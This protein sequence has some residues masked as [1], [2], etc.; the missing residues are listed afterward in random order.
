MDFHWFNK[1]YSKS[2]CASHCVSC[3]GTEV[4]TDM[5]SILLRSSNPGQ[6]NSRLSI[7]LVPIWRQT[8]FKS[9]L[10]HLLAVW[11]WIAPF[12]WA[13]TSSSEK[14]GLNHSCLIRVNDNMLKGDIACEVM[15]AVAGTQL[16]LRYLRTSLQALTPWEREERW[17]RRENKRREKR[18]AGKEV[19]KTEYK[20]VT[21]AT[22]YMIQCIWK[23]QNQ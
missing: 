8:R 23:A 13:T 6:I 22:Q 14:Q 7:H 2:T 10:C 18:Q 5:L 12:F 15:S 9:W 11:L 16:L 4:K 20:P 3:G 19:I 21:K 17:E 1:I